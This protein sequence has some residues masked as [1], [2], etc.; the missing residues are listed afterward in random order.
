MGKQAMGCF[1]YNMF[2]RTD[3]LL[4]G[5]VYPQKPLCLSKTL[6]LVKFHHLGAGQNAS[7]AVM[8]YSGY[9]IEDAIVMNKASLDRGFGR[10][11]VFR[12]NAIEMKEYENNTSDQLAPPQVPKLGE[13]KTFQ[14]G[15]VRSSLLSEDGLCRVGEKLEDQFIIANKIVPT[16]TTDKFGF[17]SDVKYRPAPVSYNSPVAAY[18]DRVILTQNNDGCKIFKV[19]TRQTRRPEPGDKFASRHGQKGV[20]GLIVGEEDMPFSESGWKPDLIMNPHG[21]PSRMTVGKMLELIGSKAACM[22]GKFAN[23]SAFGGTP[24]EEIY[25]TLIR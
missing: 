12:R 5:L 23:G 19:V 21:F 20:V 4:L 1:A 8:S 25:Q 15:Q 7:V 11:Y 2:N 22:E 18:V 24:A 17:E 3:T 13:G 14:G 10:C 6:A 16:N 9:D